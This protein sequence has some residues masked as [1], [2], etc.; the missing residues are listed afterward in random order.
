MGLGAISPG[1]NIAAQDSIRYDLSAKAAEWRSHARKS[2][3][4]PDD[5]LH[6][7]GSRETW[8]ASAETPQSLC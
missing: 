3:R 4:V 5:P 2:R 8:P 7:G 1:A 6:Q